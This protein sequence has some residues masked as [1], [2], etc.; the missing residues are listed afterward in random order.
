MQA[1]STAYIR[2]H[3]VSVNGINTDS[4]AWEL[5]QNQKTNDVEREENKSDG[6][7]LVESA[8]QLYQGDSASFTKGA[9]FMCQLQQIR[10]QDPEAFS[11]LCK[12]IADSLT[13]A[14]EGE[15]GLKQQ[16]IMGLVEKLEQVADGADIS[17]LAPPRPGMMGGAVFNMQGQYESMQTLSLV[18]FL[19]NEKE[20]PIGLEVQ[21][22][23][24]KIGGVM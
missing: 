24:S 23:V 21:D 8:M 20:S 7:A 14:A 22:L 6:K 9:E 12:T 4:S 1:A 17:I 3:G 18:D 15:G 16:L 2:R 13:R 10:N 19:Q 11:E 5:Y